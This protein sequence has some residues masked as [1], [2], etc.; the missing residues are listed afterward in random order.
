MKINKQQIIVIGVIILWII[1]YIFL[2]NNN[3]KTTKPINTASSNTTNSWTINIPES[4]K[5]WTQFL[6]KE[7]KE[8]IV[9]INPDLIIESAKINWNYVFLKF[10]CEINNNSIQRLLSTTKDKTWN[11]IDIKTISAEQIS[12]LKKNMETDCNIMNSVFINKWMLFVVDNDALSYKQI[13]PSVY[14]DKLLNI[15]PVDFS[16]WVYGKKLQVISSIFSYEENINQI[17]NDKTKIQ[18]IRNAYN[19]V[20]KNIKSL[21]L[22]DVEVSKIL[23]ELDILIDYYTK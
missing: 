1:W 20:K 23:G 2:W 17:L 5:K 15:L 16:S 12:L 8:K 7:L 11:I 18:L 14:F 22:S 3:S 10:K 6:L 19:E 13:T 9:I 4:E 21:K